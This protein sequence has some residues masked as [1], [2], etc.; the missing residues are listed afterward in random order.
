MGFDLIPYRSK[1]VALF[2][3]GSSTGSRIVEA[4]MN[5]TSCLWPTGAR[6]LGP[7]THRNHIVESLIGKFPH[8]FRSLD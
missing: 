7:I 3:R 4:P 6:L 5:E 2:F 8:A 1:G